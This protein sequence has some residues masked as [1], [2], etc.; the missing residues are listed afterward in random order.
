MTHATR[1]LLL[2]GGH[3][4]ALVL[5]KFRDFISK[6]LTVSLVT[7]GSVHVYSGMVDRKSVV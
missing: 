7:P 2:G 4:H 1:V 6:N 3:A 5:L